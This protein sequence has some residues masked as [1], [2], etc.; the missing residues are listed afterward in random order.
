MNYREPTFDFIQQTLR[1]F[2]LKYGASLHYVSTH[3][4]QTLFSFRSYVLHRLLGQSL[5]DKAQVVERDT[6]FVPAGWDSFGKIRTLREFDCESL[7]SQTGD[8]YRATIKAPT[9][10]T[11]LSKPALATADEDQ[12]FLEKLL[13]SSEES[14]AFSADGA[15]LTATGVSQS[16]ASTASSTNVLEDVA[17]KL[18]RLQQITQRTGVRCH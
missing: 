17:A 2:C 16:T 7:S 15:M 14:G 6:V 9:D 4:P 13:K 11:L 5:K 10:D 8:I 18:Q 3:R 12:L 1:V